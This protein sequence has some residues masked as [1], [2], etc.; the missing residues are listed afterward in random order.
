MPDFRVP[1]AEASERA[2]G[3]VSDRHDALDGKELQKR[4][5]KRC[6]G[7]KLAGSGNA[8]GKRIAGRERMKWKC[9]PQ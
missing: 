2:L 4:L 3:E 7:L 8:I 9:I 6:T 1:D 5:Q